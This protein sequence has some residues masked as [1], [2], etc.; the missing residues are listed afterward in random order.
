MRR[1]VKLFLLASLLIPS[2]ACQQ[3]AE[4]PKSTFAEILPKGTQLLYDSRLDIDQDGQDEW[5]VFYR[6]DTVIDDGGQPSGPIA[7]AVYRAEGSPQKDLH[8]YPLTPREDSYLCECN[9]TARM[10]DILSESPGAELIISDNC[11][12]NTTR[13]TIFSWEPDGEEYLAQGHFH[14]HRVTIQKDM[15]FVDVR[16]PDRAQVAVRS[17]Y[18]ASGG[19]YYN[20]D[21][22]IPESQEFIL[23][24][25]E[26]QDVTLSPY[27]EKVVLAFY[28]HYCDTENA[29]IYFTPYGWDKLNGCADGKCGCTR[30]SREVIQVQVINCQMKEDRPN[31]T[32][33]SVSIVCKRGQE[34]I[35]NVKTEVEWT[36]V[37]KDERWKLDN[38]EIVS[39]QPWPLPEFSDP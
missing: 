1:A 4:Q 13:A 2:F 15:T 38:A 9:C 12:G 6:F 34:I 16:M 35:D 30:D 8:A 17:T 23:Y 31:K 29:A 7:V 37:H 32:V 19:T 25:K 3:S 33:I 11:G 10:D 28:H 22:S 26:C 24:P 27:P 36:L 21:Y 20:S 39:Q 18:E 5:I 14:G